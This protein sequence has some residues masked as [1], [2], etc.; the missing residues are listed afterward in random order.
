MRPTAESKSETIARVLEDEIRSGAVREG[1]TLESEN[2]LVVRFA[3]SRSTIRKGL[4]ILATK[5]L[6]T[7]KVGIG[8]FVTFGGTVIDSKSGWSVAL[9]DSE[10]R[11]QTRI[12][13]IARVAMEITCPYLP[14]G[15]DVLAV[16]RIRFHEATG[17]GLTLERSRMP[18]RADFADVLTAG[19]LDGSLS[20]TL[21]ARDIRSHSGEEWARVL[22]ALPA[23]E[24]ELM[25]RTPGEPM[26][27]LTRLTRTAAG[28]I[29]E[30][31]E[32]DLDP[33]LF[34]LHMA[35]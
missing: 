27:R 28:A 25:G 18:W 4:Q 15:C 24:A 26:L 9:S 23:V 5:G 21:E 3:V 16:D 22:P 34:G 13:R 32:S 8:S 35:F 17:R 2:D 11:L 1:D 14:L 7:T 10:A 20:K 31:V 12:L 30:Y 29:V 6:I 19:L 33:V